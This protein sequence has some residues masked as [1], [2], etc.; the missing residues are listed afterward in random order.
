MGAG[1]RALVGASGRPRSVAANNLAP[2]VALR[3]LADLTCRDALA[4]RPPGAYIDHIDVLRGLMNLRSFAAAAALQISSVTTSG[5]PFMPPAESS[6]TR[7]SPGVLRR[8]G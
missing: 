8:I 3:K 4:V 7:I 5:A 6:G 2:L 1:V